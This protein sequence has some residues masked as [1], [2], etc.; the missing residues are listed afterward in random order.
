[1]VVGTSRKGF[2]GRL[3]ATPD[4][5]PLPIDERDDATL[6]TIVWALDQGAHAVRVHD[7]RG[8][9][10][11]AAVLDIMQRAYDAGLVASA[12]APG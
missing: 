1:V 3:L 2:L 12:A 5:R 7:V 8:A 11:A 10:R 6:A 4:G 9:V